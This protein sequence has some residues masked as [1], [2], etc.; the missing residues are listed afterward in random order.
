MKRIILSSLF[1]IVSICLF[2]Q[3]TFTHTINHQGIE[4]EYIIH[5]PNSYGAETTFTDKNEVPLILCFHGYSSSANIIMS[6]SGFNEI[7]DKEGFLVVYPQ[8]SIYNKYGKTHWNVGGYT[9]E[10][11]INDIEFTNILLDYL[12][13][14][15][16][17]NKNRIYS[18]GFS[19]GGYMSFLLACQLS[20]RFAAVSS[21]AG[22]MT[23]ETFEECNPQHP[24][25][26]LQVHGLEDRVVPYIGNS[27]S[28]P[29]EKVINYW[30]KINHCDTTTITK[31]FPDIV[32]EDNSYVTMETHINGSNGISTQHIKIIKGGHEWPG[33][34]ENFNIK[35]DKATYKFFTKYNIK[36]N[37]DVNISEEIWKFFNQYDIN[38]K[39]DN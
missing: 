21:V 13:I 20:K 18:T 27:W 35:K 36:G 24:I 22:S 37:M 39:I 33:I 7:S 29:I 14:K 5:I 25:P 2:S 8:G 38:G 12:L 10:S 32:K 26:I 11:Q 23:P 30:N 28:K 4:R 17:I 31:S 9:R 1:F 19:N 6:Y 15:Y 16:N 3:K 34:K